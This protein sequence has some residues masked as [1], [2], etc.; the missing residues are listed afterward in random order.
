MKDLGYAAEVA[1][2]PADD[3]IEAVNC[4][5]HQLAAKFPEVC[6]FDLGLSGAFTDAKV[7]HQECMVRSG[8][9]CRFKLARAARRPSG[10]T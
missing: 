9:M 3:T 10:E 2:P 6:R 4:V 7:E 8:R 1:A 5:F